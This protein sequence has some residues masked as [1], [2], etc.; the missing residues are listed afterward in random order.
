MTPE[1]RRLL[2]LARH[3]AQKAR[4]LIP[5]SA[6]RGAYS[7][8]NTGTTDDSQWVTDMPEYLELQLLAQRSRSSKN[9]LRRTVDRLNDNLQMFEPG[10]EKGINTAFVERLKDMG[11]TVGRARKEL[12]SVSRREKISHENKKGLFSGKPPVLPLERHEANAKNAIR[13]R[14]GNCSENASLA[15]VMFAEYRGDGADETGVELGFLPRVRPQRKENFLVEVV[16]ATHPANHSFVVLNRNPSFDIT[17]PESWMTS[18][19]IICDPWW[20]HEGSAFF[21]ADCSGANASLIQYIKGWGHTLKIRGS[22][23]LGE[24]HSHRFS[25]KYPDID[26]YKSKPASIWKRLGVEYVPQVEESSED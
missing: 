5:R 19:T 24:G 11:Y 6:N 10:V 25:L 15:L 8:T 12:G 1:L 26:Y 21:A 13:Y 4:L 9:H 20:F 18:T 3:I 17:A 16:E 7:V 2:R 23:Y 22:V 14:V